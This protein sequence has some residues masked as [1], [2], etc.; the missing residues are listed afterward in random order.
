MC[1]AALNASIPEIGF[2]EHFDLHPED[3]CKGFF[4]PNRWWQEITRCREEYQGL[5]TIRAG[6]ELSEPHQ[7]SK[8][9]SRLLESYP[10]D[11]ALGALHW[12][13]DRMIFDDAYF[14]LAE[15][16][17]YANYLAELQS[18]VDVGNFDVLAHMDMV[19]R[20]GYEN[21]GKYDP[22]E[23]EDQIRS[24]LKTV[25]K[26]NIALEVNTAT[27]RRSIKETSPSKKILEWFHAEG[28]RWITVGSDA[29]SPEDVG[30]GIDRALAT[31][32]ATGFEVIACFTRRQPGPT[33]F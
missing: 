19:K 17:A 8:A 9:V 26:K 3:S 13:G 28:G 32:R 7:H 30:A 24:I 29:H 25:A 31:V 21:Y 20:Y 1:R 11:Y 23:N 33:A 10:W 6:I 22:T 4:T 27:L 15:K 18:M 2:T 12:V 5:L 14:T 16:D